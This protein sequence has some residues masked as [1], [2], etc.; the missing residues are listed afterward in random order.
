MWAC[1][2]AQ[3]SHAGFFAAVIASAPRWLPSAQPSVFTQLAKSCVQL[4]LDDPAFLRL[5]LQ[6][7]ARVCQQLQSQQQNSR[8][9]ASQ[10]RAQGECAAVASMCSWAVARL[11]LQQLA[12]AAR[13]VV[14]AS[15]VEQHSSTHPSSLG[16]LWLFHD[17]LQQQQLLDGRGLAGLLTA[18]QLQ[19]G[20]REAARRQSA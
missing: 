20:A 3:L 6:Q 7:V 12:G 15:G 17:W 19:Q 14:A 10:A 8:H 2:E 18:Q 1:G 4:Q 16:R 11:D 9:T 5:V 13:E